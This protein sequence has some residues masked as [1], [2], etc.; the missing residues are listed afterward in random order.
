M[1]EM[2]TTYSEIKEYVSNYL[3][4]LFEDEGFSPLVGKIFAMLLFAPEPLS[5]QELAK[6]GG[7]SKAA[8][9]VQIRRMGRNGLC[10]K[11]HTGNDRKDYYYIS[12]DLCSSVLRDMA[13]KMMSAQRVVNSTLKA[14]STLK[15]I[16]PVDQ[17]SHDVLRERFTEMSAM[18]ELSMYRLEDL[19][20]EWEL[21]KRQKRQWIIK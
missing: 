17:A 8:V 21:Q 10:H 11:V 2:P 13:E 12:E 3:S 20:E 6:G 15:G 16:D 1:N 14:F 18:Y 5:L 9:S 7:V 19:R 4:L